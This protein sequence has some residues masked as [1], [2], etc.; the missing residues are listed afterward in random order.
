MRDSKALWKGIDWKGEFQ[1]IASKER[2]PESAF[3]EHMERLL[4]PD[5]VEPL[6]YPDHQAT[7]SIPSLDDPLSYG[8]LHHVV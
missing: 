2:P 1:E 3:Q 6:Q 4:N 5:N 8:E 7:V